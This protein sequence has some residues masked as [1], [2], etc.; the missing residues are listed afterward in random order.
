MVDKSKK[1][2][3]EPAKKDSLIPM[4]F[5]PASNHLPKWYTSLSNYES[6]EPCIANGQTVNSTV[7]RCAPVYDALTFG[8]V[9]LL[10]CDLHIE[11]H[12]EEDEWVVN[13]NYASGPDPIGYRKASQGRTLAL[14]D[15]YMPIEFI[16]MIEWSV[17]TEIGSS[18]LFTHPLNRLD[19]P[20]TTASGVM[21]TDSGFLN[22]TG[23]LPF[24]LKK[25]FCG[26]IPAGTPICQL[27]PFKR[28]SYLSETRDL[29]DFQRYIRIHNWQKYLYNG[30]RRVHRKPKKFK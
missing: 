30:Y 4:Q 7:K 13:Y 20:F 27:I 3:F 19:L 14:D 16:W 23:Y 8:Y 1:I 25:G 22:E 6:T 11:T 5:E 18:T 28:E 10:H 17:N 2:W 29:S 21:D 9:G 15:S 24:Y 12:L 26:L